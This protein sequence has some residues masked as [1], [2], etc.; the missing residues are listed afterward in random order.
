[1]PVLVIPIKRS[2]LEIRKL[3]DQSVIGTA[4]KNKADAILELLEQLSCK[5]AGADGDGLKPQIT[6]P[7]NENKL[8]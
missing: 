3:T 5:T 1:M 8:L 7:M 4:R 6:V 2:M